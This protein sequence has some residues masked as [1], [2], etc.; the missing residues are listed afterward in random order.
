MPNTI[1]PSRAEGK[2]SMMKPVIDVG[3][4]AEICLTRF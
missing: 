2:R 1:L 3:F 4:I